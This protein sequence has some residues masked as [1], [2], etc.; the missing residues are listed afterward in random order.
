MA[1]RCSREDAASVGINN[2]CNGIVL[3]NT[4]QKE[5]PKY[6]MAFD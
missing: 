1:P 2:F 4:S 3:K 5:N 6:P